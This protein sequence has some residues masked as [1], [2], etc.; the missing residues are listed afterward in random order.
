MNDRHAVGVRQHATGLCAVEECGKSNL[1]IAEYAPGP[2]DAPLDDGGA[3][4]SWGIGESRMLQQRRR[5]GNGVGVG[6]DRTQLALQS[7]E[8]RINRATR[9]GRHLSP[10]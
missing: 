8:S 5:V 2:H 7:H 10:D 6:S 3:Y 4:Q 1:W 9:H